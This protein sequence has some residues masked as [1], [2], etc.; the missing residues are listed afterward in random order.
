[1]CFFTKCEFDQCNFASVEVDV[2]ENISREI[3][4]NLTLH[5]VRQAVWD[6]FKNYVLEIL[7]PNATDVTL[8]L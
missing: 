5:L 4:Y 1:M 3:S 7:R 2:S 6:T 8:Y